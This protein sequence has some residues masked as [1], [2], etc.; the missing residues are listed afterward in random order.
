ML[1]LI[2]S[3]TLKEFVGILS[4]LSPLRAGLLGRLKTLRNEVS[5][6]TVAGLTPTFGSKSKGE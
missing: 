6:Q 3:G 5:H 2:L 1:W 4:K